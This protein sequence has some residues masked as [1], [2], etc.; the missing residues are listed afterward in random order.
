[1]TESMGRRQVFLFSHLTY[2]IYLLYRGKL[3]RPKYLKKLNKIM[4]SAQ[5]DEI[6]I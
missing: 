6:L 5:E 1:M 2:F 4:K 3:S